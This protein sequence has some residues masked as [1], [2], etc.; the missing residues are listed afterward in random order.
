M[1]L[2]NK[3]G[4]ISERPIGSRLAGE[5]FALIIVF[6]DEIADYGNRWNDYLRATLETRL[7]SD[8]KIIRAVGV[9]SLRV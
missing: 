2:V 8:G 9:Q 6:N 7:P 3:Q 4:R 5:S 1:I